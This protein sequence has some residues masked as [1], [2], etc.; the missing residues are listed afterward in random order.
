MLIFFY[1]W[2]V[3]TYYYSYDLTT[4]ELFSVLRELPWI[5]SRIMA[6]DESDDYGD[7]YSLQDDDASLTLHPGVLLAHLYYATLVRDDKPGIG[8]FAANS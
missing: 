3:L 2:L 5:T 4:S 1:F 8:C 7:G 6:R